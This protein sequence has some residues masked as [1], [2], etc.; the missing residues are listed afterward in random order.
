MEQF[1]RVND[2]RGVTSRKTPIAHVSLTT[3]AQTIFTVRDGTAAEVKRLTAVNTTGGAVTLTL[4]S[5]PDGGA[6]ATG[7]MELSAH[8]IAANTS[9]DL[10]DLIGGFYA[11]GTTLQALA[12][13]TGIVIHGFAEESL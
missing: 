2:G 9:V 13:A 7:N 10:T 4:H 6:V 12:S 1:V 3:S 5:V 11:A 8:S